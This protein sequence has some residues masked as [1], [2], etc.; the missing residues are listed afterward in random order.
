MVEHLLFWSK[1]SSARIIKPNSLL[2]VRIKEFGK[3]Q[4]AYSKCSKLRAIISHLI[5]E[6]AILP[7]ELNRGNILHRN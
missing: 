3:K 4:L 7:R 5:N 6:K 1:E 2:V